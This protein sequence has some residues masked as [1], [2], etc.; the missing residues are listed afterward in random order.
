MPGNINGAWSWMNPRT[1]PGFYFGTL[2]GWQTIPKVQPTVFA[3][4]DH[5]RSLRSMLLNPDFT[6]VDRQD[7]F[8][9]MVIDLREAARYRAACD[10]VA[11][12]YAAILRAHDAG[13]D[14]EIVFDK[15]SR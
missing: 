1:P 7:C 5:V 4:L 6:R 15:T 8:V 12:K 9:G 14:Y 10:V 2:S 3:N 11:K 13:F